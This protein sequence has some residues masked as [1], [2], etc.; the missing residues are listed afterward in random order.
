MTTVRLDVWSD[1]LCPWCFVALRRLDALESELG[2]AIEV[3]THAYLLQP[4]PR[5]KPLDKFRGYTERWVAENG[6]GGLDPDAGFVVWGDEPPPTHSLPPAVALEAAGR[7][8]G[9]A[10]RHRYELALMRAYFVEHRD[11][12]ALDV[13][14][15]VAHEVELDGAQLRDALA[16]DG[17][18][19]AEA[20]LADH[21]AAIDHDITAVPSVLLP[22]GFVLPGAQDLDTYRRIVE[23]VLARAN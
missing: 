7:M 6:P 2:D 18:E 14:V 12:S 21:R 4:Q 13:V 16:R 1:V 10:A 20:V 17:G 23:R 8:F 22:S 3:V 5:P 19:L 11:V 15:A 9:A